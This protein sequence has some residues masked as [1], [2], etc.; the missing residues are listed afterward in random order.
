[1]MKKY[2]YVESAEFC[3][4]GSALYIDVV[5]PKVSESISLW[6]GII[7]FCAKKLSEKE[8][9]DVISILSRKKEAMVKGRNF[10]AA[11]GAMLSDLIEVQ[12]ERYGVRYEGT[13]GTYNKIYDWARKN[14]I[15]INAWDEL[16]ELM[17]DISRDC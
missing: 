15:R 16:D 13:S 17:G 4:C 12:R 7:D 6:D 5:L 9:E 11:Y 2:K 8:L 14:N 1:M 3:R 10:P